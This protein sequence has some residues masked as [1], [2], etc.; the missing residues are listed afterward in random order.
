[1]P[2]WRQECIDTIVKHHPDCKMIYDVEYG[3]YDNP[4]QMSDE[5]RLE[6]CSGGANRLYVDTDIELLAP[7]PLTNRPAIAYESF[8]HWSICWSGE[9]P[10]VFASWRGQ[11]ISQMFTN[12]HRNG[13]VEL[14]RPENIYRHWG[15]DRQG[16]KKERLCMGYKKK[17]FNRRAIEI[18]T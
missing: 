4:Q 16:G 5:A 17:D 1:M 2:Q 3:D 15:S 11:V 12:L 6:F 14:L 13:G 7:L 18:N 10:G 9:N 8:P